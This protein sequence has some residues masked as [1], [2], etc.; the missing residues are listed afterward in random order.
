MPGSVIRLCFLDIET[1]SLSPFS[2][3]A[4]RPSFLEKW[5]TSDILIIVEWCIAFA[6]GDFGIMKK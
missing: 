2:I 1:A 5:A 3:M 4:N 6:I